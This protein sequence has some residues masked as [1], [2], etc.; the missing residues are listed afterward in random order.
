LRNE[1]GKVGLGEVYNTIDKLGRTYESLKEAV[2][3]LARYAPA[4]IN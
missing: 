3:D 2:K 1:G 4:P